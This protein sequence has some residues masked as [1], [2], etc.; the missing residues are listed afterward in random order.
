MLR[1]GR[2]AKQM[3]YAYSWCKKYGLAHIDVKVIER[4]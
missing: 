2:Y 4:K 3:S 1:E